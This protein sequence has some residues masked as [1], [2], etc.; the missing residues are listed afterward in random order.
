MS[1]FTVATITIFVYKKKGI[2]GQR[3]V[4][5]NEE[6]SYIYIPAGRPVI[7]KAANFESLR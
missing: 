7:I 1:L 3:W 5:H 4:S 2:S 6:F